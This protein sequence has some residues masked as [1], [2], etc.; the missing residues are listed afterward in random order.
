MGPSRSADSER[1]RM[2][3]LLPPRLLLITALALARVACLTAVLRSADPAQA[4]KAAEK[5]FSAAEIA[6]YEKEVLP[7]L[8]ANCLKCHN[9]EKHKGKLSLTSRDAVLKGGE[10]GPAVSLEKPDESRLL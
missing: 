3:R 9:E 8:K 5:K 1:M 10:L 4:K 2:R 6:F 7:I